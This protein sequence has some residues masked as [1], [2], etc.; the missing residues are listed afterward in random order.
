MQTE[1]MQHLRQ[2][3]NTFRL[4]G[5]HTAFIPGTTPRRYPL[6]LGILSFLFLLRVLGQALVALFGVTFLPPMERWYS[7]LIPYF[8]LLPIQILFIAAMAKVVIDLCRGY[9]FFTQPNRRAGIIIKW[10]SYI[11]FLSMVLRYVIT[12]WLH[13]ELRW[14]TGTIPIWFHMVLA[15]FLYTYSHYQL[16]GANDLRSEPP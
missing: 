6:L 7:G 14:F 10:F 9:G 5:H 13:P 4:F 11:Y 16:H 2:H 1:K 15:A 3:H 8:L 12:M